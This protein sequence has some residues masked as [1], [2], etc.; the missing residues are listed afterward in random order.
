MA[1]YQVKALDGTVHSPEANL[2]ASTP[3]PSRSKLN[4]AASSKE[5]GPPPGQAL[6]G[7]Q[8][9]YLKRELLSQQ[10]DFEITELASTTALQRFGAPFRSDYGEVAPID[11]DLP[12]LRF[13]FVHHVRNF[14]F[15]D[16]AREKEF[17]QD[18][19]Q[20]FLENF[21][22]KHI[23]SSEDRLEE[24]KRRKLAIKAKKLVELMMVSGIPTASGYEERIRFSELEVVDRG[25]QDQGL[26]VNAPEGHSINGW[27]IN[28][29]GVRTTSVK[30][31]VRYHQH[32]EFILRIRH[33]GKPGFF[34]GR[35]YGDF[36]K[37]HRRLRTE[38]PGK[39]LPPLPRKNKSSTASTFLGVSAE[40]DTSSVSS[41]STQNASLTPDDGGS[42]RSFV[43]KGHR[44]LA[45][46]HP[47][48][49]SPRASG[50][51]KREHVV[52]YREN[53]RVSLRA[54]LRTFLQNKQIAESAGML[55]FLTRDP[56]RLNEEELEDIDR[57]KAMDE[58]RIEEQRRFYEI[59]RQRAKELDVYMEKFRRDIVESNGLTML[60]KEIR[61]KE[62]IA[63]LSTEYQKFA[64]WLRIE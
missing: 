22:S 55:E 2:S 42:L 50:E 14:P 49:A 46:T 57:R 1:D 17:W 62:T 11:S 28:V 13:I 15:L 58:K 63:D 26:L 53:Q 27:D 48:R 38:L 61:E 21:A 4:A 35:R 34:V 23:S 37:L 25:A 24:S 7:K 56:I 54:F 33:E 32:A 45:S 19:L 52:L 20:V 16:Q 44:R 59:A 30:R 5:S 41:V 9:H 10:V 43:G 64:E 8:E 36:V 29:A 12:I 47:D 60:F 3:L 39:V 18:K 40:D 6:T 31:T 51:Y